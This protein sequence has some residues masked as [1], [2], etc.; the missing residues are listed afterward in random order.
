AV[1]G[2]A[3]E[4]A[5]VLGARTDQLFSELHYMAKGKKLTTFRLDYG[6]G[7]ELDPL[8]GKLAKIH[9]TDAK[10]EEQP[11]ID[12]HIETVIA[13]TARN[14]VP[15]VLPAPETPTVAQAAAAVLGDSGLKPTTK[16][17]Y[18]AIFKHFQIHFEPDTRLAEIPQERFAQYADAV[19]ATSAWSDKTKGLYIT[20][21]QR[22]YGY[23][24]SRNRAVP[25]ITT[26]GL[27][28]K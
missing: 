21:A 16:K 15:Q 3:R 12:R 22:L 18:A 25:R 2:P 11:A 24:E 4:R 10:P 9:I 19:N 23:Y 14:G 20:A 6:M 7:I 8:T 1:C 17:R 26:K 27:K 13:A 5:R 28:P